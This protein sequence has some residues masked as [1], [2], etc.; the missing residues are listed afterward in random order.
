MLFGRYSHSGATWKAAADGIVLSRSLRHGF[1]FLLVRFM[2]TTQRWPDDSQLLKLRDITGK[3][4]GACATR[5][6]TP[7]EPILCEAPLVVSPL[8]TKA[9]GASPWLVAAE[10]ATVIFAQQLAS[11]TNSLTPNA[12]PAEADGDE[13]AVVDSL[14][15]V[16]PEADRVELRRV[17][18]VI[19]SNAFALDGAQ[20]LFVRSSM[21]NHS[22][23]PNATHQPFR[24]RSDGALCLCI[25]CVA[26]IR[27]G[28]E[29][30]ISYADDLAAPPTE[31]LLCLRHHGFGPERRACDAALEQWLVDAD[32]DRRRQAE[33]LIS[34]HNVA[35]DKAWLAAQ[36]AQAEAADSAEART[37][38][39]TA[40]AHYAKLLQLSDGVLGS[41]HAVLLQ[42]RL[43]LA[44]VMTLSKAARSCANALP[45]WRAAL[46][47]TRRCVPPIWPQLL[48]PLRGARD[49]A[50]HAGDAAAAK[51]FGDELERVL[52]LLNPQCSDVVDGSPAGAPPSATGGGPRGAVAVVEQGSVD[53]Q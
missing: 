28:D 1:G 25:R 49:A 47:V 21:L 45:L 18:H 5:D 36:A 27:A 10:L 53:V 17:I 32:T 6:I 42:A 8:N 33:P 19:R 40:A 2:A 11:S 23:M 13:L 37:Q 34:G 7:G 51:E 50:T 38:L 39:M 14:A 24:R 48:T 29:V 44:H 35:A 30:V 20:A 16:F 4:R 3:G 43:R 9:D 52:A 26:P 22:C 12:A 41:G 31:R 15:T 46:E